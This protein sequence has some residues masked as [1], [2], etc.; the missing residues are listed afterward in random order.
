MKL[1][2]DTSTQRLSQTRVSCGNQPIIVPLACDCIVSIVPL[3]T[4]VVLGSIV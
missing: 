3:L 2:G 1:S 4:A